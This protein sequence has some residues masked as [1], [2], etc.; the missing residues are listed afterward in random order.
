M[1][2]SPRSRIFGTSVAVAVMALA[3]TSFVAAETLK[4][5]NG[6]AIDSTVLDLYISSRM[7]KPAADATP[8]ERES[9]MQELTDIYLL[10]TQANAKPF[11]E[12][13]AVKA[14]NNQM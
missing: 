3:S 7:Q 5:V 14:Q 11:A 13:P 2:I 12:D 6:V 4:T 1:F 9:A 10:T 8:A